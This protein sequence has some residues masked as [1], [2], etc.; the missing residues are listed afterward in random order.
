MLPCSSGPNACLTGGSDARTQRPC[1]AHCQPDELT[2]QG[3]PGKVRKG[4]GRS[5]PIAGRGEASSGM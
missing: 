2:Q 5:F 4:K 1:Q 3:L